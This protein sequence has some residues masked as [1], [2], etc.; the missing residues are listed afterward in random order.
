MMDPNLQVTDRKEGDEE[1]KKD[2][3]A[4]EDGIFI[5]QDKYG[6]EILKK[7]RFIEVKTAST[8]MKLKSLCPRMKMVKNA[9]K[10]HDMVLQI[11]LAEAEYVMLQVAWTEMLWIHNHTLCASV[12]ILLNKI[13]CD[14]N[15]RVS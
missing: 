8:P 13:V 5:S 4:K 15:I 10:T 3:E 2:S 9:D 7:F 6:D 11:P 12:S 1:F 14:N